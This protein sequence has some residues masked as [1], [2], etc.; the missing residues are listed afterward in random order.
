M[1]QG[2]LVH[3]SAFAYAG[4]GC[5]LLGDSGAGKSHIVA[6]ALVLGASLIADDQVDLNISA[7]AQNFQR[8]TLH[9]W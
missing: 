8:E 2:Q 1:A 6:Q 7:C 5:L 3:A 4:A 9:F